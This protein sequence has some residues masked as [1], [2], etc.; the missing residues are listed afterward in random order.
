MGLDDRTGQAN[1]P[2]AWQNPGGGFGVGCITWCVG[3]FVLGVQQAN[4]DQMF[5]ARRHNR[6]WRHTYTYANADSCTGPYIHDKSG[7]G[8][9]YRAGHGGHRQS[10]RRLHDPDH[11]AV[12]FTRC[13]TRPST[14]AN[15][16]SNGTLQFVECFFSIFSNSCLPDP[17]GRTLHRFT[18]PYWDD[19]VPPQVCPEPLHVSRLAA[20]FTSVTWHCAKPHV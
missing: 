14:T 11:A 12:P 2:A 9:A 8:G 18:F 10:L 20:V 19:G 15:V 7:I 4:P 5:P 16:D 6:R 13:T 3:K 1:N 17:S